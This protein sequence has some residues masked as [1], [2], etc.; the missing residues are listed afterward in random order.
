M[1]KTTITIDDDL[2]K[3]LVNESIEKY[4]STR[5]L[6]LLIN[7]RLRESEQ[8]ETRRKLDIKPIKMGRK[9]SEEEIEKAI[10][11]GWAEAVEWKV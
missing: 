2:Y 7:R 6:S 9:I 10:E 8:K 1:V 5:K 11:E 3:K 4:G